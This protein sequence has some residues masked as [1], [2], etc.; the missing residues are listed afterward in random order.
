[1]ET[2]NGNMQIWPPSAA[3]GARL[4]SAPCHDL[5]RG[6]RILESSHFELQAPVATLGMPAVVRN[7][8]VG[9]C[10]GP[11]PRPRRCTPQNNTAQLPARIR[12]EPS[13]P[14]TWI[15]RLKSDSRFLVSAASQAQKAADFIQG[16]TTAPQEAEP[17]AT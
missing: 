5:C 1:M 16:K 2:L 10:E 14:K 8:L 11:K 4:G 17:D 15:A 9:T 12:G 7:L 13:K 6:K 3:L